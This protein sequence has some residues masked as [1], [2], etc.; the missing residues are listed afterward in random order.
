VSPLG[1]NRQPLSGY[2]PV[3]RPIGRGSGHMEVTLTF[4]Q[5]QL[6]LLQGFSICFTA[7]GQPDLGCSTTGYGPG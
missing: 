5:D 1:S 3:V 6:A 2:E 7:P 4:S